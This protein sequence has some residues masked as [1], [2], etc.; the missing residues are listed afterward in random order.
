MHRQ[1]KARH[2]R[3]G[4]KQGEG[5]LATLQNMNH[6]QCPGPEYVVVSESLENGFGNMEICAW[7]LAGTDLCWTGQRLPGT[8][9]S[10]LWHIMQI[11]SYFTFP[12]VLRI[13]GAG[14][15]SISE[16]SSGSKPGCTIW[17]LGCWHSWPLYPRNQ[18][19]S[20]LP[21][22][23]SKTFPCLLLLPA[24]SLLRTRNSHLP[25]KSSDKHPASSRAW[26]NET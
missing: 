6:E 18:L 15:S 20:F 19:S 16:A 23:P 12:Y 22:V 9:S 4:Q 26:Q 11:F 14:G 2:S 24:W 8:D 21:L 17:W 10:A 7:P 3:W 25:G 5:S 13:L 1:D